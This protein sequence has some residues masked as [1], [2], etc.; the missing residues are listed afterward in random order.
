MKSPRRRARGGFTLLTLI[1]LLAVGSLAAAV[2]LVDMGDELELLRLQ[3]QREE[4][5]EAAEGGLMEVLNAQS[6]AA[7]LPDPTTP[8]LSVTFQ[9]PAQ[10]IFDNPS[11]YRGQRSYTANVRLVRMAP[12][13]ESSHSVVR[14]VMYEIQVDAQAA[15]GT[16]AGVEAEVYRVAASQSGIIQPRVHGR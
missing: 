6:L 5:R 13:L 12:M 8:N 15:D 7:A 11:V 3:R 9:P 4:A 16:S 2:V 1:L 14:A 10:S